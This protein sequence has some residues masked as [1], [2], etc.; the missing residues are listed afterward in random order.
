MNCKK[1][2]TYI[3]QKRALVQKRVVL[4][5][6]PLLQTSFFPFEHAFNLGNERMNDEVAK[7][8]EYGT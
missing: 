6:T 5:L 3:V 1:L 7:E 2:F 4:L 8:C